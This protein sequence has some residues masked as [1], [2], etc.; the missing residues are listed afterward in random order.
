MSVCECE[1]SP[2][3]NLAQ[4][5]HTLNGDILATKIS[6]NTGRVEKLLAEKKS[7]V[8]IVTDLYFSTLCRAPSPAELSASERLIA[9]Y[10]SPKECYEDLLWA[11]INSKAFLFVR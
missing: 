8:E 3:A 4:A 2:D 9:E 5:L 1:R 7:H 11:L 6:T 10:T